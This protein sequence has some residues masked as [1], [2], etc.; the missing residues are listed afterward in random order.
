MSDNPEIRV[1][2]TDELVQALFEALGEKTMTETSRI[3]LQALLLQARI[4]RVRRVKG[5][6]PWHYDAKLDR[7][8]GS[9]ADKAQS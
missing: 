8:L 4:L 3:E 7:A 2:V 6:T 1:M 5:Q 9:I